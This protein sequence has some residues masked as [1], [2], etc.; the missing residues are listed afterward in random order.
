MENLLVNAGK[1][2][3]LKHLDNFEGE[4]KIFSGLDALESRLNLFEKIALGYNAEKQGMGKNNFKDV[5]MG[6]VK[7]FESYLT[8]LNGYDS[9]KVYAVNC[10]NDYLK[11]LDNF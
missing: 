5:Y 11:K 6:L 2:Y 1:D 8:D 9:Q 4:Q 10:I 3:M 7:G